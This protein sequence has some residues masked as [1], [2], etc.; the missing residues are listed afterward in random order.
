MLTLIGIIF[1]FACVIGGFMME[2]GKPVHLFIPAEYI[3]IAGCS[4]GT[5]VAMS[6]PRVLRRLGGM[7][8]AM[9]KGD[10]SSKIQYL[11]LLTMLYEFFQVA[12]KDGLVG[13]EAHVEE[14]A[15]STIFSKYPS[16][17]ANHHAVSFLCDTVKI[18]ITAGVPPHDL[19][20]LMD[21]D[22]ETRHAEEQQPIGILQKV[23]DALPGLGI[24]AAVLGIVI[25]MGA[26][27]G[28]AAEIGEKVGAALVGTFLGIL[29][30]YGAVQPMATNM[31]LLGHAE[32]RFY[33]VM[34][35]ALVAFWKHMP[36][37]VAVEFARR[38]ID[39]DLRPTFKE[40]EE[41]CRPSKG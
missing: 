19:E 25:T 32:A 37:M 36:A 9:L 35:T 24:V 30:S 20:A 12:K 39:T 21:A 14:P 4:A 13:L 22:I 34:K 7:L 31:E 29:L 15:Q 3:I 1:G 8:S 2:G 11:E 5:L 23:G 6:S 33:H 26:I 38:T 10:K 41:A 27:D 17:L 28:H 18:I 16:F 40:L